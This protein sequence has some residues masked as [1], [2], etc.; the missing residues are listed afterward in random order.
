MELSHE[1]DYFQ[2]LFGKIKKVEFAKLNKNSNL[3]I[4]CEDSA[5]IVG[6][7]KNINFF[8]NLNF[9]SKLPQ[10]SLDIYGKDFYIKAVQILMGKV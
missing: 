3:K 4:D 7:T 1:I 10:R 2:W 6:S 8:I 5:I 9:I